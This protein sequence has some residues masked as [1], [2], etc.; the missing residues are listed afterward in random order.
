MG[1]NKRIVG[2]AAIEEITMHPAIIELYLRSDAL[3]F[4]DEEI[5]KKFQELKDEFL[6]TNTII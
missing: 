2:N 6:K 1:F 5:E 4:E 3:V